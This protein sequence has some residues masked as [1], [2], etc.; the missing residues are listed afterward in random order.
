MTCRWPAWGLRSTT[1]NLH[2]TAQLL[3]TSGSSSTPP[4]PSIPSPFV[5]PTVSHELIKPGFPG[6]LDICSRLC[7]WK[8]QISSSLTPLPQSAGHT[9]TDAHTLFSPSNTSSNPSQQMRLQCIQPF[10]CEGS[11]GQYYVIEYPFPR[12]FLELGLCLPHK[13]ARRLGA[14]LPLPTTPPLAARQNLH[15]ELY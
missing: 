10:L 6:L 11:L 5:G 2:S 4:H 12:C 15:G 3:R 14:H 8:V 7:L 1:Y 9:N 13:A